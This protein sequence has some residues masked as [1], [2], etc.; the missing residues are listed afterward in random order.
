[1]NISGPFKAPKSAAGARRQYWAIIREA[2]R[3]QAGGLT[4]GM[5]WITFR[6]HYP[7]AA[8]HINGPVKAAIEREQG[9]QS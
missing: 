2:R 6:I 3:L 9:A 7:E 1:M 8:A 4:F 5:D